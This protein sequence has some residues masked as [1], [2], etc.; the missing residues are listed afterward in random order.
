MSL[1]AKHGYGPECIICERDALRSGLDEIR[2]FAVEMDL[3]RI[4]TMAAT[5]LRGAT[6]PSVCTPARRP[7]TVEELDALPEPEACPSEPEKCPSEVLPTIDPADEALVDAMVAA[8]TSEGRPM[9]RPNE[10]CPACGRHG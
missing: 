1:C 5:F 10:A 2:R 4:A 7:M 3:N 8:R 6:T 9:A